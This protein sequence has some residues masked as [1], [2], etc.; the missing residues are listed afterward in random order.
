M[1]PPAGSMMPPKNIAL[2]EDDRICSETLST[3]LRDQGVRVDV[4]SDSNDP[5]IQARPD[6]YDVCIVDLMLPGIDGEDLIRLLRRRSDAGVLVITAIGNPE[7]FEQVLIADADMMLTEPVGLKPAR[8][9]IETVRLRAAQA[10]HA[11]SDWALDER[12]GQLAAPDGTRVELSEIDVAV[13]QCFVEAQGETVSRETLRQRPGES[14]DHGNDDGLNATM[15]R[16]RRRVERATP[17]PFPLQSKSRVG[18]QF[19]ATIK[20]L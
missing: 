11:G 20:H 10:M 14:A 4:F 18:Y 7:V 6:D 15:Y 1:K 16:L 9:A 17:K 2:I 19:R 3:H 13:L 8:V 5:L 12:A